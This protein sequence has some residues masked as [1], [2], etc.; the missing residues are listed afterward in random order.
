M[1]RK[2]FMDGL[3]QLSVC[4]LILLVPFFVTATEFYKQN[5]TV[6]IKIPC[7]NN[8]TYCSPSASCDI[9]IFY[10]NNT[11]FVDNESMDNS[12]TYFNYTLTSG[13]TQT[14]GLYKQQVICTDSGVNGY[15]LSEF[16]ITKEGLNNELNGLNML[17]G[18][19]AVIFVIVLFIVLGFFLEKKHPVL[20][21][22]LI[23]FGFFLIILLVQLVR[24]SMNPNVEVADA[25]NQMNNMYG[26]IMM[27]VIIAII[28]AFLYI[29]IEVVKFIMESVKKNRQ[30]KQGLEDE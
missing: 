17:G 10:P 28:Y 25:Q 3:K 29:L 9:T 12:G 8:E 18:I 20:A 1:L 19:G 27:C 26:L 23:L 5:E 4:L 14:L 24:I 11:L 6:N 22:P 7:I 15:S 13:Q 2:Y 21:I 30:K 16:R